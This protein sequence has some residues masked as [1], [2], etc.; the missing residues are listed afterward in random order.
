MSYK[1]GGGGTARKGIPPVG[2]KRVVVSRPR[3][4]GRPVPGGRERRESQEVF[5]G[6]KEKELV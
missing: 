3:D 4:A 6:K 1:K 5:H 2:E